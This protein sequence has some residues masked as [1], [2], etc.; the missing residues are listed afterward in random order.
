MLSTKN[1]FHGILRYIN[2]PLPLYYITLWY[3][4]IKLLNIYGLPHRSYGQEMK[5][6]GV[7]NELNVR[8]S[9]LQTSRVISQQ[10]R[11]GSVC[12]TRFFP[13]SDRSFS[14]PSFAIPHRR[15]TQRVYR[16]RLTTGLHASKTPSATKGVPLACGI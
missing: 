14:T 15:C 2:K 10:S 6:R 5:F 7:E 8:A 11:R 13:I 9:R 16:H 1:P 12:S 3:Y 4:N